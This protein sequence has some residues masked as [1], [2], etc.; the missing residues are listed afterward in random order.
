MLS[1]RRARRP[2]QIHRRTRRHLESHHLVRRR[3]YR[4]RPRIRHQICHPHSHL[5]AFQVVHRRRLV[6]RHLVFLLPDLLR[7]QIHRRVIH[8]QIHRRAFRLVYRRRRCSH[9]RAR[10]LHNRRLLFLVVLLRSR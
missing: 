9:R 1:R 2:R 10:Q 8:L 6:Y 5:R 7:P 4:L 3:L